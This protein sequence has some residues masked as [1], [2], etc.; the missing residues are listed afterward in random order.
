MLPVGGPFD[1]GCT[2][3]G[4]P[5]WFCIGDLLKGFNTHRCIP[6]C[7]YIKQATFLVM[8]CQIHFQAWRGGPSVPCY[9]HGQADLMKNLFVQLIYLFG[10][11]CRFQSFVQVISR[12]VVLW[13]EETSTYT[14]SRFCTINCWPPTSNY[15]L[16]HLRSGQDSN[17]GLRGGRWECYHSATVPPLPPHFYFKNWHVKRH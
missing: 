8:F 3:R 5:E 2:R 11:Q 6:C 14:W 4:V 16:S 7:F 15:Q 9:K 10:F 12:R 13:A 17:S 1:W